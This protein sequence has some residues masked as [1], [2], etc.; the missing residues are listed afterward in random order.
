M[1]I[2]NAVATT[3]TSLWDLLSTADKLTIANASSWLKIGFVIQNRSGG[4]IWITSYGERTTAEAGILVGN[5]DSYSVILPNYKDIY[6]DAASSTTEI[7]VDRQ[8]YI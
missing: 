2:T 1:Q 6:I 4:N 8:V 3:P 7:Y 5:N